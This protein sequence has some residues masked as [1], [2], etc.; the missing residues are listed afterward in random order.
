MFDNFLFNPF[1][2]ELSDTTFIINFRPLTRKVLPWDQ[3]LTI[4][5]NEYKKI[6]KPIYLGLSG[7]LDSEIIAKSFL[8]TGV[9]FK[10]LI[11]EYK[12]KD[13]ILNEHDTFYAK[14]F[15]TN[16]NLD[17]LIIDLDFNELIHMVYK[18]EFYPY[19][20]VSDLYQYFQIYLVNLVESFNGFLVTGSGTQQWTFDTTLKF[21]CSSVYFN[22]YEYMKDKNLYHW[23]SFFWSTPELIRSYI[24]VDVVRRFFNNPEAFKFNNHSESM[25]KNVYYKFFPNVDKRKKYHGYEQFYLLKEY[26]YV[27]REIINYETSVTKISLDSFISQFDNGI[28]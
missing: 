3:E 13:H 16:N 11:V 1:D 2:V 12:N 10:P 21:K 17:P 22:I 23:P 4:A 25:K 27:K 5:A 19:Y 26:Q 20:R 28:R 15:C 8:S 14:K 24:N 18:K 9:K 7:G 6:E